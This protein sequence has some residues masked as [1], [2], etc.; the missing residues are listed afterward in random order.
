[1]LE[2]Y[3]TLRESGLAVFDRKA[4]ANLLGI[5]YASTNPVLDR[6]LKAGILRRIKRDRYVLAE[7]AS[8][9]TRK[10]ANELVKP[11][12]IS[13]WTALS[14]AGATT[15]VP[16]VVQSVTPMRSMLIE[17]K[18]LPSFEYVHLP[19]RLFFGNELRDDV[20]IAR[21]EKALLD[22]LYVQRGVCDWESMDIRSFKA[23]VLRRYARV[24]S[25]RI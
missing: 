8:G 12:A 9:Q 2:K 25:P 23:R 24:F 21:P 13:L 20:W 11:S 4:T 3:R 19:P 15:Q 1:M 18:G 5:S 7:A 22:L 6:L 14:D 10:I 17:P 16:R